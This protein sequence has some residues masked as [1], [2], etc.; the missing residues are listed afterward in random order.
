[1]LADVFR[2]VS[3]QG[4]PTLTPVTVVNVFEKVPIKR[5]TILRWAP[6]SIEAHVVGMNIDQRQPAVCR[7]P[8][9]LAYPRVNRRFLEQKEK[10]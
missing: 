8:I 9:K 2:Y 10:S 7:H 4:E 1:M 5:C 6:P 3:W